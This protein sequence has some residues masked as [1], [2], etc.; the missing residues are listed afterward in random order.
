MSRAHVRAAVA[1]QKLT[2]GFGVLFVF[3]LLSG[4][5]VLWSLQ[6]WRSRVRTLEEA[7]AT[8]PSDELWAMRPTGER[9]LDRIV[10]ALNQLSA[11]L[12]T[13]RDESRA[14]TEKLA[15]ADRTT[16][17]GRMAAQ[18]AH[19]IRN[20]IASMRLKA[21]NALAKP[22]EQQGEALRTMLDEIK[23]LDDL[24]ERLLAVTRLGELRRAPVALRPWLQTRVDNL[25]QQ[26]AQTKIALSGNAP[27]ATWSF[28]EKSMSRALDNL[29]LNAVQ[30]TPHGGWIT[31]EVK[32]CDDCCRIAVENC[33]DVIASNQREKIFEPFVGTRGDG[34][35]LGLSIA[36]EIAE[37]HGGSLRCVEI[38]NGARFEIELPCPKS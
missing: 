10:A 34:A 21:E 20:P 28:D 2:L 9:E 7:I 5:V 38:K 8:T 22:L 3:A 35:G 33:G 12:R 14:L 13:A 19:E 17:L 27:D 6:S 18:V 23:R 4:G 16:A 36:R 29:L 1:Y 30:H 15:R 24:L 32:I 25:Q 31:A 37:A 26:A 11:K